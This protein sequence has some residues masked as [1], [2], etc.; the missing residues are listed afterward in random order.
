MEEK[1]RCRMVLL[2]VFG[3][4]M[5]NIF[6]IGSMFFLFFIPEI[7][8][9]DRYRGKYPHL[10]TVAV[11]S[12]LTSGKINTPHSY[13]SAEIYKLD[14]DEYGRELFVYCAS[15]VNGTVGGVSSALICQGHDKE[16]TYWY[17]NINYVL[18]PYNSYTE[19][20]ENGVIND[21]QKGIPSDWLEGLKEKNDWGKEIDESKLSSA[22]IV[23]D[24][25][26]LSGSRVKS[27]GF[28][29][30]LFA[31]FGYDH[32]WQCNVVRDKEGRSIYCI[33]GKSWEDEPVIIAIMSPE[34]EFYE[35]GWFIYEIPINYAE[36]LKRIKE[37]TGWNMR[38]N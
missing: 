30:N 36:D 29:S 33:S 7:F 13:D 28:Y 34:G 14:E 38:A 12:V 21:P 18:S 24:P 6:V 22:K 10:Y 32:Q 35:D 25:L 8:H 17:D 2:I 4:I 15:P 9:M 11:Y 20:Y 37:A 1:K 5:A 27:E 31:E 16:Y 26:T 19:E 3:G 23:R